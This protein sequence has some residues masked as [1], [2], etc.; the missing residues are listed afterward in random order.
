MMNKA[1]L[2]VDLTGSS[3]GSR[4]APPCGQSL[5]PT[6]CVSANAVRTP[7]A[8]SS[9]S[10]EDP[11]TPYARTRLRRTHNSLRESARGVRFRGAT[12]RWNQSKPVSAHTLSTAC[13]GGQN[14]LGP[15]SDNP[16]PRRRPHASASAE[17]GPGSSGT[18]KALEQPP[19]AITAWRRYGSRAA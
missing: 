2:P 18:S 1:P 3:S 6:K 11:R 10:G 12:A 16:E 13:D 14:L 17:E 8:P 5:R 4:T 19:R 7:P 15:R 9:E